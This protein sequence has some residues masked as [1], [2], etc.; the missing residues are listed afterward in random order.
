ME[1]NGKRSIGGY[2]KSIIMIRLPFSPETEKNDLNFFNLRIK[3]LRERKIKK[4]ES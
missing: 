4:D 2:R 3:E 1:K